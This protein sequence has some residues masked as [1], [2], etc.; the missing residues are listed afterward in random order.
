MDLEIQRLLNDR[1]KLGRER[2]GHG[3]IVDQDTSQFGTKKN[4]WIEMALEEMLDGLVY[5]AAAIIRRDNELIKQ[6]CNEGD[7]EIGLSSVL[8]GKYYGHGC[9]PTDGVL[10]MPSYAFMLNCVDKSSNP[11][12]DLKYRLNLHELRFEGNKLV[13]YGI[14][15]NDHIIGIIRYSV[16]RIDRKY[17]FGQEFGRELEGMLDGLTRITM[18]MVNHLKK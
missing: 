12:N 15:D 2:Y 13:C 17:D 7:T 16:R 4:N 11:V 8:I 1:L 14:D 5:I 3:V 10:Y 6:N 9:G 18:Q